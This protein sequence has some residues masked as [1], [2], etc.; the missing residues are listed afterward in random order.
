MHDSNARRIRTLATSNN[1]TK[2]KR[3]ASL[4]AQ[5]RTVPY[6]NSKDLKN[7]KTQLESSAESLG[8]NLHTFGPPSVGHLILSK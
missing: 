7:L 3:C 1:G 8:K 4:P 6:V 2:L 5:K